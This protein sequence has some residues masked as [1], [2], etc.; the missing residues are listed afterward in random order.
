[1]FSENQNLDLKNY[2]ENYVTKVVP[3]KV[4]SSEERQALKLLD[5][6]P[7]LSDI[8]KVEIVGVFCGVKPVAWGCNNFFDSRPC[9]DI[10]KVSEIVNSLGLSIK[11]DVDGDRFGS[12]FGSYKTIVSTDQEKINQFISLKNEP[13]KNS[14]LLGKLLG[15]P[16]SAIKAFDGGRRLKGDYVQLHRDN[17]ASCFVDFILSKENYREE[18]DNYGKKIEMKTKEFLP[19]TYE[20][21]IEERQAPCGKRAS[22]WKRNKNRAALKLSEVLVK[23]SERLSER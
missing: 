7:Y 11:I 5:D 3:E 19:K 16:E 12:K 1:M 21:F 17:T 6:L 22:W 8:D 9:P 15:Y 2:Q 23:I 4:I 10:E 18:I 20:S 13:L 14:F